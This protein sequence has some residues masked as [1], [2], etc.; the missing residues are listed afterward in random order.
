MQRIL[1]SNWLKEFGPK[2][3]KNNFHTN[4][5]KSKPNMPSQVYF[6]CLKQKNNAKIHIYIYIKKICF[7]I[8]FLKNCTLYL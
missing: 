6:N 4:G 8:I 5:L 2:L 3:G 1:Q 7:S